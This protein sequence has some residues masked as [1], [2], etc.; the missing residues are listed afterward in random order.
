MA[1]KEQST[2]AEKAFKKLRASPLC[3]PLQMSGAELVE[4][5]YAALNPEN[6][7][8]NRGFEQTVAFFT[9]L[10]ARMETL[11]LTMALANHFISEVRKACLADGEPF[12]FEEIFADGL[13]D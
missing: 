10:E 7:P 5:V 13:K 2:A 9:A 12:N 11:D 1:K 3:V 6:A 4:A 8:D